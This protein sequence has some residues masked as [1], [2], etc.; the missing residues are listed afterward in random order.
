M[1]HSIGRQGG[2]YGAQHREAGR[3][4]GMVYMKLVSE[5]T[6]KKF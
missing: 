1:E 5:V 4:D 3:K 2:M 6:R